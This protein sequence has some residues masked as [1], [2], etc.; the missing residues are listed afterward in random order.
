V[1]LELTGSDRSITLAGDV[2]Q[3]TLEE[4]DDA[5]RFDWVTLLEG[6]GIEAAALSPLKVSYR[7]TAEITNFARGVLGPLAHDEIPETTRSGPPVELLRFSSQGE[8]V[9]FLADA[10]KQLHGDEPTANVALIARHAAQA[11]VYHQGLDR[12]EVPNV[13][14][15]TEQD[16]T[17]N[18]GVD[19]TDVR[20]TKGL[21]F[22]EVVLLDTN[23]SS[24]PENALARRMLYVGATRAAHQ[25]WCVASS[26]PSKLVVEALGDD[27]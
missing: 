22:D 25:L 26:E 2:A 20:Q 11:E 23:A 16:F 1:L 17:W 9:A 13:R 12:A 21:E 5:E 8:A 7:S 15:V 6:L 4:E 19:V 14:I 3:R 18:A 24:Y 10:L 27:A